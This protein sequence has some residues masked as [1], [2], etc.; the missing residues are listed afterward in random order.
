M[1][2]GE[3]AALENKHPIDAML[4]IACADGL[5]TDFYTPPRNVR[6]DYLKEMISS[7]AVPIFGVSDGGAHTKFFTGGRYSTEALIKIGRENHMMS[8]EELH[9]RLSAHP[10]MC[11]GFKNRGTLVEGSWADI[12]VYDFDKLAI[13]PMEIVRDFPGGEWR[14]VQR[15]DGYR[16][17]TVNGGVTFEDGRCTDATPGHLLRHGG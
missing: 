5:N 8:L 9:W 2:V 3:I 14:R 7:N 10:A 15:A 1:T 12:V 17:I 6:A 11:A 13:K 16:A 4:D